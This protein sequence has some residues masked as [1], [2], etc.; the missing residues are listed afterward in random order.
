MDSRVVRILRAVSSMVNAQFPILAYDYSAK[1]AP[2]AM[3]FLRNRSRVRAELEHVVE[4][5]IRSNRAWTALSV[6][7]M[8]AICS[9]F[10]SPTQG[11]S[12]YSYAAS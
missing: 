2:G 9:C 8:V 7:V 6:V 4:R 3:S 11:S 10:G 1:G 5:C 12:F